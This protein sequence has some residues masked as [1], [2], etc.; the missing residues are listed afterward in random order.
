MKLG[1]FFEIFFPFSI[2]QKPRGK[3]Y[4][5]KKIIN[6]SKLNCSSQQGQGRGEWGD[7]TWTP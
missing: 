1:I 3:E 5:E 6:K 7:C 4:F 2:L